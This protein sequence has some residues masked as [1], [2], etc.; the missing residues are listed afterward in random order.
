MARKDRPTL[1]ERFK[2]AQAPNEED[3]ADLIDSGIHQSDDIFWANFDDEDNAQI[4]VG[5]SVPIAPLHIKGSILIEVAEESIL[6]QEEVK[7]MIRSLPKAS[8]AP[9]STSN[10]DH[11]INIF[12]HPKPTEGS[13]DP[14]KHDYLILDTLVDQDAIVENQKAKEAQRNV[15]GGVLF[16]SCNV[17]GQSQDLLNVHWG[18]KVGINTRFAPLA[19]L[20]VRGDAVKPGG[21]NWSV[22]SDIRIKKNIRQFKDGLVK[23]KK[24]LPILFQY[25]GKAGL[26]TDGQ[27][28]IGVKAQDIQKALPYAVKKFEAFLNPNDKKRSELLQFDPSALIFIVSN[29]IQELEQRLVKLEKQLAQNNS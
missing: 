13:V 24:I 9:E 1:K 11:I 20:D 23:L 21:G 12:H 8:Y 14:L 5:T 19:T 16:R 17:E 22:A 18:G 10:T 25:N 4:G 15:E 29:A 28:M 27:D 7:P 6:P 2:K 3:F 26:P